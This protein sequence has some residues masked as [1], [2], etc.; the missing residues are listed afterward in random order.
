MYID[1][2]RII[3][4][5]AVMSAATADFFSY[6]GDATYFY[7]GLGACGGHST[8][9][10]LIVALNTQK[11]ANGK[12]CGKQIAVHYNGKSVDAKVV[13]ECPGCGSNDID[14]SPAAF[15]K[16]APLDKGRIQV[17]WEFK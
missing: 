16:L 3:A 11:Y 7:P 4:A 6:K 12:H 13:D 8:S 14:L 1:Y 5:M 10:D 17:T 9:S 15:K 2:E